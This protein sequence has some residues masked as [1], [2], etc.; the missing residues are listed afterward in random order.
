[1]ETVDDP[2]DIRDMYNAAWDIEDTRLE[3]HKLGADLTWRYLARHLPPAGHL[4]DIGCGTGAYTFAL[5]KRGYRITAIDLAEELVVRCKAKAAQLG[6]G[7]RIDFRVG[8]ARNLEEEAHGAF[9]TVLLM[10]PLYHLVIEA[11]RAAALRSAYRSRFGVLADHLK[12]NPSWIENQEWVRSV[13]ERGH[14]PD[15]AR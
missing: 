4:L 13:L 12:K 5:A 3:R 15:S 9:D 2:A 8:D 1:M 11:D 14:R 7:D 6:L 10:G